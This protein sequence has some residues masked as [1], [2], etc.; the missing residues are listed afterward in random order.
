MALI[1]LVVVKDFRFVPLYSY[2]NRLSRFDMKLQ[3]QVGSPRYEKQ[4]LNFEFQS[5]AGTSPSYTNFRGPNLDRCQEIP[6]GTHWEENLEGVRQHQNWKMV[7]KTN[8][9][10]LELHRFSVEFRKSTMS[11]PFSW[12]KFEGREWAMRGKDVAGASLGRV[13]IWEV[14]NKYE[15][16]RQLFS[17]LKMLWEITNALHIPCDLEF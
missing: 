2:A 14:L 7:M 16:V 11:N 1:S 5:E 9:T 17:V 8:M 6:R 15:M 10:S 13:Q 4:D 12:S 3:P